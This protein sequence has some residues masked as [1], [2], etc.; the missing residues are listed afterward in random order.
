MS[1]PNKPSSNN[2]G[3]GG[4]VDESQARVNLL[5]AQ[6]VLLEKELHTIQGKLDN[7]DPVA[8][9]KLSKENSELRARVVRLEKALSGL[10]ADGFLAR[11][12]ADQKLKNDVLQ[13]AAV[14][15]FK[16][17]NLD[18]ELWKNIAF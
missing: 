18:P 7:R 2:S 16:K 14:E 9:R 17:A 4:V 3:S 10:I 8:A 11:E 1:E 6:V 15:F 13:Q 5:R 12:P